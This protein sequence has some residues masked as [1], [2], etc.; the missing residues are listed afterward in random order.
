M[1]RTR[2][3]QVITPLGFAM[4]VV[5]VIQSGLRDIRN[6]REGRAPHTG[7]LLFD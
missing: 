6:I 5:R 7:S 2:I 3:W 4:M 1:L